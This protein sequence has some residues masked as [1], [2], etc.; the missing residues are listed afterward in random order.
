MIQNLDRIIRDFE[1]GWIAN[2]RGDAERNRERAEKQLRQIKAE[3]EARSTEN[4]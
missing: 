2:P 4:H 1:T 3:L